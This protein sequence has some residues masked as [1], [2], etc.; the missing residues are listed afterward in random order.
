MSQAGGARRALISA[1]ATPLARACM[2]AV[3]LAAPSGAVRG[4]IAA[5]ITVTTTER[6]LRSERALKLAIAEMYVDI[7][8]RQQ[9]TFRDRI[10]QLAGHRSL[11]DHCADHRGSRQQRVEIVFAVPRSVEVAQIGPSRAHPWRG[12]EACN[13]R[14]PC[15]DRTRKAEL[16]KCAAPNT[17]TLAYTSANTAN[18]GA[19]AGALDAA[20]AVFGATPAIADKKADKA[21]AACQAEVLKRHVKLQETSLA[22]A[23]KAKKT[24]LKG[25]KTTPGVATSTAVATAVDAAVAASSKVTKAEN[26]VNSGLASKCSDVIVD[27]LFDFDGATTGNA[28][29]LCV[30][31]QAKRGACLALE[32]ADG[33]SLACPGDV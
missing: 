23:N 30:I 19:R 7:S 10:D 16:I 1:L 12:F 31:Q 29:A 21:G 14:A 8:C 11:L 22:E 25:S 20:M 27:A 26:G 17:P 9:P 4:A 13:R 28:L 18:A 15:V 32:A 33:L 2:L 3:V 6:G 5:M 24:A